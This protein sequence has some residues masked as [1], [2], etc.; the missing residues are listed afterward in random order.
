MI[1]NNTF[2]VPFNREKDI[3]LNYTDEEEIHVEQKQ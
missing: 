2:D 3:R 1:S